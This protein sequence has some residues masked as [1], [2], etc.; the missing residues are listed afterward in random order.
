MPQ[1][2]SSFYRHRFS[3]AKKPKRRTNYY[4]QKT[5]QTFIFLMD[6]ILNY[7]CRFIDAREWFSFDCGP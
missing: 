2:H 6:L 5:I 1:T 4:R 7:F 3:W